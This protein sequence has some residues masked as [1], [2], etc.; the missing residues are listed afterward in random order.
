MH[1][2]PSPLMEEEADRFS[3]ELLMPER[4]I[5]PQ[6]SNLS[7]EKLANLKMHWEVS[8]SALLKHSYRL[9][10]LTERQYKSLWVEMGTRGY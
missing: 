7:L 3:A 8:M 2:I 9:G 4:A 5:L 10:Q 6:L 1:R